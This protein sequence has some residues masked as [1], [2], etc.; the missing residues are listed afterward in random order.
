[1]GGVEEE[2][3]VKNAQETKA[4]IKKEFET[5]ERRLK[6]G[7]IKSMGELAKEFEMFYEYY[8]KKCPYKDEIQTGLETIMKKFSDCSLVLFKNLKNRKDQDNTKLREEFERLTQEL[9][10]KDEKHKHEKNLSSDRLAI[11]E[12]KTEEMA[13]QNQ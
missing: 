9:Q 7:E 11:L 1:M 3:R 2:M 6:G 8:R 13:R 5:V 4:F 10:Q 12:S